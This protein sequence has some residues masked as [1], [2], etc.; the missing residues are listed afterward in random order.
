[1]AFTVACGLVAV[2]RVISGPIRAGAEA[3]SRGLVVAFLLGL[4]AFVVAFMPSTFHINHR[5]VGHGHSLSCVFPSSPSAHPT[6]EA[7]RLERQGVSIR[8]VLNTHT[9]VKNVLPMPRTGLPP[10]VKLAARL[11]VPTSHSTHLPKKP[12]RPL[13]L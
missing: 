9:R 7:H 13:E 3:A 2:A 8:F 5:M 10:V 12:P 6:P 4:V 11:V 1:M